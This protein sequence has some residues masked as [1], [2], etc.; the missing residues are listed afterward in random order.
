MGKKKPWKTKI[1]RD[2]ASLD[3]AL[4][5]WL[6]ERLLFLAQHSAG[7]PVEFMDELTQRMDVDTDEAHRIWKHEL[8]H[9]GV[10]LDRYAG[11]FEDE[12][13]D[14][15]RSRVSAGQNAMR[16]VAKWLPHLWD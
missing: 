16:W 7:V 10:A 9:A 1:G 5:R 3:I 4:A 8:T 11:Q 12:S 6:S 2:C 14:G 13:I 15:Q